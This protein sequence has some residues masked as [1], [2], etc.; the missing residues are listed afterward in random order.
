MTGPPARIRIGTSG[1]HYPTGE[2]TWDGIFYPPRGRRNRPPGFGELEYYAEHF[3]TVEVNSTFYGVPRRSVT[4]GWANRTPDDFG[5]SIKLYQQFTHPKMY[6]A[7]TGSRDTRVERGDI[8]RLL[9]ERELMAYIGLQSS[10]RAHIDRSASPSCRGGVA[11]E[12]VGRHDAIDRIRRS[13]RGPCG[14][15]RSLR[16]LG[17]RFDARRPAG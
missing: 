14:R 3:D 13:D 9:V 12:P 10:T 2:G 11:E 16:G 1:W 5:F 17:G 15:G 4:Q 8:D 7:S 6:A